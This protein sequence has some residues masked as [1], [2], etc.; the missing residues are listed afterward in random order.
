MVTSAE[1]TDVLGS[2]R[3]AVTENGAG[4]VFGAP[5]AENGTVLLPVAKISGG[6][7]GG[8][9]SGPAGEGRPEGS[10][11]G[12]GTTARGL[13]V[14]V[15]RNGKVSWHPAIDVNRIVLGGQI[16]AITALLVVRGLLRQ[17]RAG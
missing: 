16:V 12:F 2:L 6:A 13:G 11:G 3:A 1:G 10:G 4:R 17:R 15:L 8:G 9:G 7:G 5:V 14:F